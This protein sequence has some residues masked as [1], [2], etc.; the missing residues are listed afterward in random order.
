MAWTREQARAAEKAYRTRHPDRIR[1]KTNRQ[2][3]ERK[4]WA[5]EYK[6][7]KCARCGGVFHPA[8]YDFHHKDPTQKDFAPARALR[9]SIERA[10]AELDKCDLLCSN[11]HRLT[12]HEGENAL[13]L[14]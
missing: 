3:T 12:H 1:A 10:K 8:V 9:L 13:A 11:C 5:I 2:R 14:Q 4:Q 7:G 6:G